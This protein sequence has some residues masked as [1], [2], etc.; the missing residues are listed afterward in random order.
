MKGF[1]SLARWVAEGICWHLINVIVCMT[2]DD[3]HCVQLFEGLEDLGNFPFW[4]FLEI[5][6]W[7]VRDFLGFWVACSC[8]SSEGA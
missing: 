5:D 8:P 4:C 1:A 3:S 2:A 7:Q 6:Y